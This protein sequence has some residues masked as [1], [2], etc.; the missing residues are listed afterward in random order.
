[1]QM[2][3]QFAEQ[4]GK[5]MNA[6]DEISKSMPSSD[7]PVWEGFGGGLSEG[8]KEAIREN[9]AWNDDIRRMNGN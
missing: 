6:L 4:M 1:M 7:Q 5:V 9:R 2:I 8:T 3:G